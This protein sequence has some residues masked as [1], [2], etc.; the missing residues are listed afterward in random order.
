MRTSRTSILGAILLAGAVGALRP[1]PTDATA[2]QQARAQTRTVFAQPL[3]KLDG[4]RLEVR[5]VE[6][7][8]A[9]GAASTPHRHPC[10]VVGYV[11]EGDLR[12]HVKGRPDTV[13]RAGDTFFEG[14]DD[15]H[16]GA[17]SA[18][19]ERPA[20]FLAYFTC[21]RETPLSVPVPNP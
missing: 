10:P 14:P 16:L 11:L 19:S 3:P 13:Y 8:Y 20:R 7:T 2:Q 12:S 15:I 4:S 1:A 9:P 21:D 6:V 5:I 18:S 17:R